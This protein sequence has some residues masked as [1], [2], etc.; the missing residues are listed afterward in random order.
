M[1]QF[2]ENSNVVITHVKVRPECKDAFVDWQC[3]L[4]GLIAAFP[5]FISLE[6]ISPL[7]PLNDGW[8]IIQRFKGSKEASSWTTSQIHSHLINSLKG[9]AL[10]GSLNVVISKDSN[11][12]GGVTEV[13][14]TT[15]TEGREEAYREWTTRIHQA[16]AK[17][18]GFR[19]IYV[20]SPIEGQSRNWITFLQFDTPANLDRWLNS[21]EREDV[22]RQSHPLIA[23][24]ESQRVVSS[25][26]GWFGSLA[27]VGELPP[28]WK[29]TMLVL[30]VLFP[31]V[32]LELKYLRLLT[33]GNLSLSVT[34]FIGNA[35]SVTLISWPFMPLA[36]YFLGWWLSPKG[37]NAGR[38]TLLGTFLILLLYLIEVAVFWFLERM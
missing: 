27:K 29:Q 38:V 6:V 23:S 14:I 16:E 20:Q 12:K 22:L 32:M 5:G 13:F 18:P 21:K 35:I 3:Q 1:P 33:G 11:L 28:V 17:F 24:L 9:L 37:N 4:N 8:E 30:L 36:I 10:E 26:G 7:D 19:G 31:I 2:A 15:V 25:Y 34:T